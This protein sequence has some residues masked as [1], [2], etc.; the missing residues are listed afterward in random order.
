MLDFECKS[1]QRVTLFR[2]LDPRSMQM[3]AFASHRVSFEAGETIFD[4]GDPGDAMYIVVEGE[5]DSYIKHADGHEMHLARFG[6]GGSFGEISILKNRKRFMSVK[7]ASPVLLLQI[8]KEDF[9]ELAQEVPQFAIAV[10]RD[11][12]RRLDLMIQKYAEHPP[13]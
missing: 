5:I 3:V 12:A 7:A 2:D 11:L 6:P 8:N 13:A 10:M 1:L 9:F 4:E